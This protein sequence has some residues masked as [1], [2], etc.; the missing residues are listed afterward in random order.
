MQ[1]QSKTEK[2]D[3]K[4]G[5]AVNCNQTNKQKKNNNL[6]KCPS[7][8]LKI[9]FH[10]IQP[11][12]QRQQCNAMQFGDADKHHHRHRGCI[13]HCLTS[14]NVHGG[15]KISPKYLVIASL[16]S[17]I[18]TSKCTFFFS[19]NNSGHLGSRLATW[20]EKE[21]SP[22]YLVVRDRRVLCGSH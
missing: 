1:L 10:V 17:Y 14:L 3:L 12:L 5:H 2:V 9:R 16:H 18:C 20:E 6:R 22:N 11:K 13:R 21:S 15:R 8:C 7:K 19:L 4:V